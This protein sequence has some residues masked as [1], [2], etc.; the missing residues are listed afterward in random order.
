MGMGYMWEPGFGESA[1]YGEV[2]RSF[3]G[4]FIGDRT[5]ASFQAQIP[6]PPQVGH[7]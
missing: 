1:S 6:N 7:G 5:E 4:A 2:L 3:L